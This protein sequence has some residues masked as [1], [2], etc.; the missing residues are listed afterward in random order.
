MKNYYFKLEAALSPELLTLLR[1]IGKTAMKRG[2]SAYL[3]GGAVRDILLNRGNLDLDLSVEGKAI[4]LARQIASENDFSLKTHP[5]FGTAKLQSKNFSLDLVTAR[6]ETYERPGALPKVQTGTIYD[7]LARRD[8]TI[9]AM[10][11]HLSP[12]SFGELLDPHNGQHDLAKKLIRILHRKSFKDDPTRILRA[13]RYEQRLDFHLESETEELLQHNLEGLSTVTAERLWHELELI[14]NEEKPEKA[15]I[16][17]DNLG[18]LHML[19]PSLSGD[20]WLA[21]RFVK[22]RRSN[23]D[24]L[25]LP[26]IYLSIIAYRFKPEEIEKFVARF[27]MAGWAARIV[28]NTARLKKDLAYLETAGLR[29]S[30]IYHRL[31][32][33]LPEAVKGV[34]IASDSSAAKERLQ[35]YLHDLVY[36]KCELDGDSL[37]DMG[38]PQGEKMGHILKALKDARLDLKI[39]NLEEEKN[40]V[41]KL[42]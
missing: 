18:V 35:F 12:D 24:S 10:A 37:L 41:Y 31:K 36:I 34:A 7:D 17:A 39:T 33:H 30:Q 28:R 19:Y 26:A 4:S 1:N 9:N 16:R 23:A 27:K 14:L 13:I 32:H 21:K 42:M 6:S 3:I 38:I 15:I 40:L 2:E 20:D 11:I 8:F 29:P 5:R 25:A 22:A